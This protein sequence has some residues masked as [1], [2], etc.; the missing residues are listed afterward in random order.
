M[1]RLQALQAHVAPS[2]WG[3]SDAEVAH[4]RSQL[5]Q[6]RAEL[7][8]FI[9]EENCHPIMIRLAWHDSGTFDAAV[10]EWPACGGANGSIRFDEELDHGANAGL[11]KAVTFLK[12]FK[13]KFAVSWADLIQMASAVAIELA[14]GPHIPMRY[15]RVDADRCPKEG[16]LPDAKP[17][18]GDGAPDAA[19]HLRNV[20]HRMGFDDR[21]I[22]ALSGAH[23]MG[24]AFKERSG[25]VD[26]GYGNGGATPYTK[27]AAVARHDGGKGVGMPGGQSWVK[28]WLSF[29]NEYFKYLARGE[30]AGLLWLPTDRALH[31]DSSFR[32]HFD[33]YAADQPAFFAE[34]A[35]VHA[36]LSDLGAKFDPP[37]GIAL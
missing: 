25:V 3:R 35:Q 21:E 7:R 29:D 18:F 27:S 28:G 32:G 17:P 31:E 5:A 33:R 13:A 34:Y 1:H 10:R 16:N 36:K 30:Q 6:A 11:K 20:F 26:N 24:R 2:Y 14:G 22:V 15:G 12:E 23:T 8:A 9:N 19:R 4:Y 37:E